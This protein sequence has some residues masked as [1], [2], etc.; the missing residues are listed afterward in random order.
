MTWHSVLEILRLPITYRKRPKVMIDLRLADCLG[1]PD[2]APCSIDALVTDPPYG[3]SYQGHYWD[4]DLPNPQIWS[5]VW[6]VLKPGSFGLVFSSVRLQ[7]RLTVQLEDAG[8]VIKDVLLWAYLN[9]MP[10]S[11]DLGLEI[12]K[13]LQVDSHE[14]G[15]YKYVQGYRKEGGGDYYATGGKK[16]KAPASPLGQKYQG[17]GSGIKPAYEPIILIQKPLAEGLSIGQNIVKYGVGGLNLEATRIPYAADDR[18]VGHNPHPRGRVMANIVRTEE[19]CDGYDK[20]FVVPKVRQ[21]KANY[22][23]HPTIKPLELMEQL[24]CLVSARGQTVLDPFLGSGTTAVAAYLHD[25]SCL[26]FEIQDDYLTVAQSR[27]RECQEYQTT[28]KSQ[29][30]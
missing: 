2:V 29:R 3:I 4:K 15:E 1:L 22:N 28:L 13:V 14:V 8:F 6:R 11:R 21:S 23:H 25:R 18:K 19:W 12:D 26:G 5:D 24:V 16:R 27:I 30:R 10:K 9:G 17:F 20:F 7:H